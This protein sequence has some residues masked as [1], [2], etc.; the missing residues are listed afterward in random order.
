MPLSPPDDGLTFGHTDVQN[1]EEKE[2]DEPDE[3]RKHMDLN[4]I[5]P[6]LISDQE[7]SDNNGTP[8]AERVLNLSYRNS[9]NA[10]KLKLYFEK[11]G[12]QEAQYNSLMQKSFKQMNSSPQI[13]IDLV[14][15]RSFMLPGGGRSTEAIKEITQSSMTQTLPSQSR[16]DAVTPSASNPEL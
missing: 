8:I 1:L 4:A 12:Q 3:R 13:N 10:E 16:I 2:G 5:T 9:P 14:N 7:R 11:K 6:N 15:Q